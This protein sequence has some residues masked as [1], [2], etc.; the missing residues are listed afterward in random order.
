MADPR[1]LA[2]QDRRQKLSPLMAA[3]A[4]NT[5]G[6]KLNFC[7]FGCEVE[8]LDDNGYCKH[9]VGFTEDGKAFEPMRED[10]NKDGSQGRRKVFG[11]EKKPVLKTDQLVQITT[12]YRVYRASEQVK[13]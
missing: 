5:T 6:E 3:K 10:K 1:I 11:A 2:P 12:S 13:A 7:P 8:D 9:L 4:K